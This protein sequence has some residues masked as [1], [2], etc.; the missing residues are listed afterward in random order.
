MLRISLSNDEMK[1]WKNTDV[2]MP[3][4]DVDTMRKKTKENPSWIHFGAGN[5]FRAF[6]AAV[7]Q[8]VLEMGLAETGL[9]VAEGFDTEIIDKI[10]EPHDNLSLLVTLK[11][12]GK[13]EKRMV[14]SIA[15][16]LK[17]GKNRM[18]DM[19]RLKEIFR[20]QSLQMASFTI[21]E[22]GYKLKDA[23]GK[24]YDAVCADFERKPELAESYIGQVA[25]LCRERYLAGGMPI[26]L[27]SMDN[28]SHN[29]DRLK[30]A[31]LDFA[32]NWVKN[33]FEEEGFAEW[34]RDEDCVSFPW[35]MIDKITPRPD[36]KV[37]KMLK[38]DGIDS[39][40]AVVTSKNTY[41]APFVNAE[42]CEYLVVE[43][44]FPAG[45]PALEEGGMIFT[46]RKTVDLTEKMKVC[47]CLN[48]LHTALAIFGC[49]LSYTKISEE[50]KNPLL[51][52]LVYRLG[53]DEGMPVVANP[54]II[55]PEEFLK[56]VLEER[57]P[58]PFLP[59][60][61]QRIATDTSQKIPIR[62]GET[63]KAY[64]ADENKDTNDLIVIPLVIAG[65]L[66]YL[67]AVDDNGNS[68]E[69]S[70]DP[71]YDELKRYFS[72]ISVGHTDGCEMALE[73]ILSNEQIF[74]V[75]LCEIGIASRIIRYFKEMSQDYGAVKRTLEKY[76][77]V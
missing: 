72:D 75:N 41:I 35:T 45:R 57:I 50:M 4:F 40:D 18:E 37:S 11:A 68:F 23:S 7:M 69:P 63:L 56:E 70:P 28:F 53:F 22:K 52:R 71:L 62:F 15:E 12:N 33:G 1:A 34:L 29:G 77:A 47:T 73:Q 67:M 58:N 61:P 8:T 31:V 76:V 19:K 46:D 3:E 60:T 2:R 9:I 27:V 30:E 51:K 49:L 43:D 54:G 17:M 26:A 38:D 48:P 25:A 14:A 55:K 20:A 16:A 24:Y 5:I 32:D 66:R 65:W 39:V 36:A 13:V 44:S 59:D 21:T 64:I 10:Y 42:E 6:P 74:G